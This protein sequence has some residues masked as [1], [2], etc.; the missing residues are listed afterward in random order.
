MKRIL[1]LFCFL[2][3]TPALAQVQSVTT[4]SLPWGVTMDMV[5]EGK[6]I[7]EGPGLCT[8]CH[9][10]SAEGVVG[11]NLT[12]SDWLQAKGSY[13][14]IVEVIMVGVPESVSSTGTAMPA[15]GGMDIDE[16]M[17]RAAAAYVWQRSHPDAMYLPEGVTEAMVGRGERIF[18]GEGGCALC[19]GADATGLLGPDLTDDIWLDA[20]GSYKTIGRIIAEGIPEEASTSGVAMPPR[21]GSDISPTDIEKVAAYVWYLS[22]H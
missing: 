11:P 21:G 15:R 9:G 4:D 5:E 17:V 16:S 10:A 14:S 18:L 1:V 12:D 8:E 13:E 6:A 7:F 22:R 20:K 19:H 3:A 2:S